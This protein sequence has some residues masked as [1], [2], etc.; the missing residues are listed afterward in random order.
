MTPALIDL[1]KV[2]RRYRVGSQS[3]GALQ[4]VDL[5]IESGELVVIKGA[6]GSGKS[7]LMNLVG[8]LDVATSGIYRLHGV[9]V[10]ALGDRR[11]AAIRNQ[12]IGFVFQEF[13]LLSGAT[14]FANV[15][16]PLI[17]AR[18]PPQ[19]RREKVLECLDR[20]GL[21]HRIDHRPSELSGGQRQRVAIARALVN[22]P[23]I[24]LADEPTGNLDS[25]SSAEILDLFQQLHAE[26]TTV[27]LVTHDPVVAAAGERIVTLCDG[28]VASDVRPPP[29]EARR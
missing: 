16:M 12:E 4:E 26:G 11:L 10:G 5:R 2:S 23:S 13:H 18:V 20:V 14:A 28:R 15:E 1:D 22:H 25:R 7:T 29:E 27:V 19:E 8:C 6:S 21:A 17:Y 9:E 3:V 24:L